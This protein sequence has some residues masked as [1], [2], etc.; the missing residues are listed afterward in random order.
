MEPQ[1]RDLFGTALRET[2]E[3][4]GISPADVTVLGTLS[5]YTTI[6]GFLITPVVGWIPW[7]YELSPSTNEVD[8]IFSIPLQWLAKPGSYSKKPYLRPNGELVPVIFFEPY[9]GETVWGITGE[10][11][12]NFLENM[13]L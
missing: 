10:I 1:D 6:T 4:T 7:P 13:G 8:R 2:W 11:T 5:E 12:A 9:D 3:E